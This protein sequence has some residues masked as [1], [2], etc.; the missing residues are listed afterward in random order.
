MQTIIK[1]KLGKEFGS[2]MRGGG[3]VFFL[4][5][6]YLMVVGINELSI[7]KIFIGI[8]LLLIGGVIIFSTHGILI[9]IKNKKIKEYSK[10]FNLF[11]YGNWTS[12][13]NYPFVT[14]LSF[15]I[16]TSTFSRSN[17]E[18]AITEKNYEVHLLNQN[19]TQKKLIHSF[20]K[21]EEAFE[22]AKEI[23]TELKIEFTQYNPP[24]SRRKEKR[25]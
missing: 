21:S 8:I 22:F 10:Y 12:I 24:S 6:I 1:N 5:S 17:R 13:E 19:H 23:A 4:L 16:S 7:S 15:D 9:D 2:G 3:F 18:M 25:R 14:V 20:L 11:E